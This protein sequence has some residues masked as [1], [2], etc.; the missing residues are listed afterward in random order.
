MNIL[1]KYTQIMGIKLDSKQIEQ[2]HT[3]KNLLI[4]WN[5]KVNLTAITDPKE[6]IVKHF[7]DSMAIHAVSP[8]LNKQGFKVIDVGS[9]AGFPGLVLQIAFPKC[10]IT[11]LESTQKK[12]KFLQFVKTKLELTNLTV[13]GARAE[14]AAH[15]V[16]FREVFDLV[17]AR[18]VARLSTLSELTLPFCK[19][20][21]LCVL[22]KGPNPDKELTQASKAI[23]H[24][25]GNKAEL[26]SLNQSLSLPSNNTVFVK[27]IKISKTPARFPRADGMPKK[28]PL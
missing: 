7:L 13:I 20:N 21:G 19:I 4:E 3:Y 26:L 23:N 12:V 16:L 17:V 2:L 27:L 24:M 9:G 5:Q 25:G 15:N 11:L 22:H 8:V 10:N 14:L 6:I 28:S 1:T 18:G